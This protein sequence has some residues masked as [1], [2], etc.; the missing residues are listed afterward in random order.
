[1]AWATPDAYFDQLERWLELEGAAERQRLTQRMQQGRSGDPERSGE[2]IVNLRIA[3][4]RSGLGGRYL[5]DFTKPAGE[6]LPMNRLKVGSPVVVS[7]EKNLG[8]AGQPGVVSRR[9]STAIQVALENWPDAKHCRID[10]SPDERTRIRQQGA[11]A[12]TRQVTGSQ[13]RLAETL[14]GLQ[15]PRFG[16]E[17]LVGFS[18]HLNPP[19]EDAVRFALSARDLAILHGPPGTGKTTTLAEVVHQ[20]V[21]AGDKV[22]ACAPSN[23]AVDNL[24]E[25]LVPLVPT[26]VRVGHP[27]RVFEALRGHTLD[28]LVE[29]DESTKIIQE[30]YREAEQL[31]CSAEKISRSRDAY[32]RRGELFGE[33]KTLRSHARQLER[34]VVQ[35]VLDSADVIC[36]TM[37]IDDEL[38]GDRRFPLVVIDEACQSTEPALWQ[39]VL[40]ADRIV[41]AGDHCQLPPTVL[42]SEAAHEG[43]R[44]SPMERLVGR[45]GDAIFRRLTVQ[46]RMHESIMRF[47]SEHFYNGELV[48]DVSVKQ[49]TLADILPTDTA[50]EQPILEFWDTAGAGWDEELEPDGESK[51]NPK[52]AGWVVTQ[53]K[54]LLDAGLEAEQI[55]VIAPYAAQVR[56][57]RNRLRIDGLEIDTV[58]GFQ[59]R[60]KEA[61][62]LTFVRSNPMGEIGFLADARRSNV[63]LTRAKRS[64]RAIGDSATLGG[65][66]FY[67]SVLEYFQIEGAYRSVWELDDTLL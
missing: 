15:E 37:T 45:F 40:R 65:D 13:A 33:A 51:R 12:R 52:E 56:L 25:R 44:I 47:S 22:L 18:T 60:E 36:T 50:E 20:A 30:M 14:L 67:A 39:A 54:Q 38:L 41:L 16:P 32:R 34:H 66:A 1:M 62:I 24:L 49:H 48:A 19:Q 58:D 4:H 10:L 26:V 55:A 61:V 35:Q 23:T 42:S 64:L 31:I 27:A 29:A 46:Y 28:E 11:I 53:V 5:I 43:L 2:T 7:N 59:G 9:T 63:A 8:E 3:D 6:R 57:L 21:I 17:P